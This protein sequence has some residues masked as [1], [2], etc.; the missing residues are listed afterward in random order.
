M[1]IKSLGLKISLLVA[2]MVAIIIIL[3]VFIVS[4]QTDALIEDLVGTQ[5]ET[6]NNIL[7]Q[8]IQTLQDDALKTANII[9]RSPAVISAL[10][11]GDSNTIRNALM[12][13]ADDVDVITLVDTEGNVL[14]RTHNDQVGDNVINQRAINIALTTG[15]GISTIEKGSVVGLSTRG[16]AAIKRTVTGEIIGAVTVGHNLALDKYVDEVKE[17]GSCEVTILDGI[18]RMATTVINDQTGQRNI[19]TDLDDQNIIDVVYNQRQNFTSQ[20]TLFGLPYQAFYSPLIVDGEVIGSLSTIINIEHTLAAKQTKMTMI[21]TA[22]VITAI[23]AVIMMFVFCLFMISRPLRKIGVFADK[24]KNGELGLSK[25]STSTIDVKSADEVGVMARTLEQAY[26]QLKGYIGEIQSKMDS[27]AHGDLSSECMYPFEGDFTLIKE[28]INNIVQ[29]LNNTMSEINSSTKQ[30]STGSKQIADGAQALAQGSTEQAA[31]VQE[32]SASISEIAT[33][34]KENAEKAERAASLAN[35]IMQNAEKGS[36]QMG[37]MNNAVKEINQASQ[38]ISK[39]IK[40]IDDIAFQTNILA[41]NAAVEAARAGQHGKGF[42]VVAEEVRNL[43]GKSAE[44]ARD[45]GG[46]ISNSME[47][48]ELGARIAEETAASLA[49]IVEGINESTTLVGEI[50]LS[51]EV[52]STGIAQINTGIDQ[53]AQV[54]QQNSATAQE[55]AAASEEMSGQSTMLEQLIA[56]F[57]LKDS[58]GFARASLPSR[59]PTAPAPAQDTSYDSAPSFSGGDDFGKY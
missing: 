1:G 47:K 25:S 24:I 52:Q 37:E 28:S 10:A 30:V 11:A 36:R 8:Y 17:L 23:V 14:A 22:A 32:L 6:S 42:A 15:T 45:T 18:T 16:S 53:V 59:T 43:A 20:I 41:L 50:A 51:S 12:L 56:Q 3:T 5:A 35:S 19:G 2:V 40:V 48:A 54:V 4:T 33:Q 29:N 9:S 34:T 49:D 57:K 38:S 26:V 39:V 55:S 46:L 27:L 7:V 44:A 21:I 58:G 31:S 13:Y